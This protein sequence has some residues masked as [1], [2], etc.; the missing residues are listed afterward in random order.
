MMKN[1]SLWVSSVCMDKRC[2]TEKLQLPGK[3]MMR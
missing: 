2:K 1:H 3:V